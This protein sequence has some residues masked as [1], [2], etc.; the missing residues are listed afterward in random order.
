MNKFIKYICLAFIISISVFYAGMN[1]AKDMGTPDGNGY[2]LCSYTCQETCRGE[3][4]GLSGTMHTY[5]IAVEVFRN[6]EG[7]Y[8]GYAF[9]NVGS[10][11][12]WD[13]TV[14]TTGGKYSFRDSNYTSIFNN[15][16]KLKEK[17]YSNNSWSC[18]NIYSSYAPNNYFEIQFEQEFY[19]GGAVYDMCTGED[20]SSQTGTYTLKNSDA[21]RSENADGTFISGV[22]PDA[23]VDLSK[24]AS[25]NQSCYQIKTG[26]KV[27]YYD[28]N[29]E[30]ITDEKEFESRCMSYKTVDCSIFGSPSEPKSLISFL[31][32]LF[33][34]ISILGI[35]LLVIMTMV[36]FIKALTGSDDSG[37]IK[38]F[39]HTLVRIVAVIILLLLPTI[40][41]FILTLVNRYSDY[42]IGDDGN[43]ICGV[44]ER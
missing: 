13:G 29:E 8:D 43:V 7:N 23:E 20:K 27:T 32:K 21:T 19:L 24:I 36:E 9:V 28:E 11:D 40:I 33:W 14:G 44:G 17:F 41:T 4:C 35:I 15:S 10:G 42:K 2:A 26:D 5:V 25:A 12:P 30:E 3:G 31:N 38:G 37:L 34:I 39:K 16:S 22:D 6:I 18:P 1:N